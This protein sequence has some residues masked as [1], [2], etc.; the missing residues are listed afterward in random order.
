MTLRFA[1]TAIPGVVVVE[2]HVHR[3]GRGFLLES[4]Q[5]EKYRAGGIDAVF[6]Q[7]NHSH[8]TRGTLRGLHAQNPHAQGKLLRVIAGEVFDVA[9]DAR[10]G[11]PAYGRCV[12]IVLSA[13]NFKQIYVPP[14]LLHGFLVTSDEAQVEY[15]CTGFYRPDAEFS[16]AW[17]DP[18]LA[19]P[20]PVDTPILS[21]KDAAAPRLAEVQDRLF[22][23]RP[24][25]L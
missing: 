14:G 2:P 8:S 21:A 19:I 17:N 13:E 16:V 12:S 23:Y 4:Y 10:R 7:D 6:V 22:D 9:V 24:A 15:K 18:D 25:R 5:A 1:P 11:S 3:D 20:W